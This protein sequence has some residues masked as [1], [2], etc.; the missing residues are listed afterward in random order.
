[1]IIVYD[2]IAICMAS[3]KLRVLQIKPA[4]AAAGTEERLE[5]LYDMTIEGVT[6]EE[7]LKQ[8]YFV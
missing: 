5:M 3:G 4:D 8:G 7:P 2:M 1:M 6:P